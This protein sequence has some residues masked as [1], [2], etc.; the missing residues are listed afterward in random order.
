[1]AEWKKMTK[2]DERRNRGNPRSS[3]ALPPR[4][5]LLFAHERIGQTPAL[6]R[7]LSVSPSIPLLFFL[8]MFCLLFSGDGRG[9]S[10]MRDSSSFFPLLLPAYRC[11][12]ILVNL[13]VFEDK[14]WQPIK[15]TPS[16][17]SF[18][19]CCSTYVRACLQLL[20]YR[21]VPDCF[22]FRRQTVV[23]FSWIMSMEISFGEFSLLV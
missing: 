17:C 1:L 13:L 14:E 9:E 5:R 10:L 22:F 23:L 6:S 3:P 2:E 19:R 11:C 18:P 8:A 16:S 4:A 20:L 21:Y 7:A 12:A 15:N